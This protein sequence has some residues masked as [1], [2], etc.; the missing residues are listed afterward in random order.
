MLNGSNFRG[1]IFVGI[2]LE[3]FFSK[4]FEKNSHKYTNLFQ[5]AIYLKYAHFFPGVRKT[6]YGH[7]CNQNSVIDGSATMCLWKRL[8]A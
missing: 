6:H 4:R 3:Q 1:S 5:V 7:L 8:H 2:I